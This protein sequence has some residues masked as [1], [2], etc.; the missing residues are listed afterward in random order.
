MAGAGA[1][2][3]ADTGHARGLDRAPDEWPATEEPVVQ[4]PDEPLA[5][6][7]EPALPLEE[8]EPGE[9]VPIVDEGPLLLPVVEVEPTPEVCFES[10]DPLDELD[11]PEP[12]EEAGTGPDRESVR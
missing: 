12:L 8:D 2:G 10:P 9:P 1:F 11:V 4:V 3:R 7:E 6:T 5:A